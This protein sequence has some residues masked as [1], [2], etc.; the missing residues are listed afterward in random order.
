MAILA[1]I[2][3]IGTFLGGLAA[4]TDLLPPLARPI[5]DGLL[6]A[7]FLTCPPIWSGAIL[8]EVLNGRQRAM[9]C[10]ALLFALPL[11]LIPAA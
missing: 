6:V 8:P 3:C 1:W 7:S 9:A 5:A 2:I 11:V 10:L 4:Q